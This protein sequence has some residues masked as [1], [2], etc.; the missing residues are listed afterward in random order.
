MLDL[1]CPNSDRIILPDSHYLQ[2]QIPHCN[3]PGDLFC[4]VYWGEDGA[5]MTREI[6]YVLCPDHAVE[7]GYCRNCGKYV[8]R[9][10]L[11]SIHSDLHGLC[12]DCRKLT[13]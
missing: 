5:H 4:N 10:S 1:P 2:C 8:G 12:S 13:S 3:K 11:Q 7:Y 6:G 9:F